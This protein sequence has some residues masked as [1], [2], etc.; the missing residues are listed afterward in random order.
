MTGAIDKFYRIEAGCYARDGGKV[1]LQRSKR[2]WL[3]LA[4]RDGAQSA[5]DTLEIGARSTLQ[6]AA[7][8]GFSYWLIRRY[9]NATHEQARAHALAVA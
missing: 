5:D 1:R 3:V 4:L 9:E 6:A 7:R 8:V 2:Q